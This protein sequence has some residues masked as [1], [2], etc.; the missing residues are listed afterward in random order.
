M[1]AESRDENARDGHSGLE[2]RI[3]ATLDR[4]THTLDATTQQQLQQLRRTA[5]QQT[6]PKADRQRVALMI[7]ASVVALLLVTLV[8]QPWRSALTP[9]DGT[10]QIVAQDAAAP[11]TGHRIAE[12]S[13]TDNNRP[14]DSADSYL[15]EEP[16]LL[17]DW[18]MLDAIGEVP[19]A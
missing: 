17:A 13:S 14:D 18:D 1:T 5:L 15:N 10:G 11:V 2:H 8:S 6:P 16:D 4:S 19:D 9:Q 7:V 3:A 12:I